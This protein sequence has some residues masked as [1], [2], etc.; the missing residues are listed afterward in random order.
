MKGPYSKKLCLS[1]KQYRMGSIELHKATKIALEN[2]ANAKV[3]IE[4]IP[5]A[6]RIASSVYEILSN[7]D[8]LQTLDWRKVTQQLE[9]SYKSKSLIS[10]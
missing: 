7:P 9:E 10:S 5:E 4:I 3:N 6:Q 2:I 1:Q 8:N